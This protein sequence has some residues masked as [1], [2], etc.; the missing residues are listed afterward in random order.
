MAEA[1]SPPGSLH[2][3]LIGINAYPAHVRQLYGCVNDIDAVERLLL[4]TP[5][6]GV[7]AEMI[8]A[9]RLESQ[10]S[11]AT[12]SSRLPAQPATKAN[13]VKA[14]RALTG[15]RVGPDDRVLIYYSG[16]GH[17]LRWRG[18]TAWHEALVP[19][20][21]NFLYD[22]EMDALINSIAERTRDVTVIL[23]CCH[24]AS[25]FRGDLV[26]AEDGGNARLLES[27]DRAAADDFR[28]GPRP[29]ASILSL[30]R[31][32]DGEGELSGMLRARTP[33][34][35][36]VAAAQADERAFETP[37]DGHPQGR[38]TLGLLRLVEGLNTEQRAA[39][40]WG[41]IW[42]DL[43][44]QV[45][46]LAS[47]GKEQHPWL[48]GRPERRV[49]GGD[50]MPQAMDLGYPVTQTQ[51][52]VFGIKAGTLVGVTDGAQV[53]V[54]RRDEPARF[55]VLD[56]P[57]DMAARLGTLV[58]ERAE[59][60]TSLARPLDTSFT[61]QGEGRGR[62]VLPGAAARLKVRLDSP[63]EQ[64]AEAL[65]ASPL[66]ELVPPD[67]VD[68]EVFVAGTMNS[69]WLIS[70]AVT[71]GIAS[72]PSMELKA[73]RAGI[74]H[75]AAYNTTLRL[76][77]T[78]DVE[79]RGRL[80]VTLLDCA[81]WNADEAADAMRPELPEAAREGGIYSLTT[82]TRIAIQVAHTGQ[83]DE[84]PRLYVTAL[85]CS[86]FGVIEKIGEVTLRPAD[87]Q[88]MWLPGEVGR[89][90]EVWPSGPRPG[91]PSDAAATDRL[92]IIGTTRPG[93]ALD[94]LALDRTVQQAVD[95]NITF[96]GSLLDEDRAVNAVPETAAP[97]ELWT[98]QII[99]IRIKPGA[100][101]A[102]PY[103]KRA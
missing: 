69:G 79:L 18:G 38:L 81:R 73:L 102:G 7:P 24:A 97:A 66:L 76:G 36:A 42:V 64:A 84:Q 71:L 89:P 22:V 1:S 57:E 3:V 93:V 74:E 12:S 16:H 17:Q 62:L 82:G 49:F 45:D 75:Y 54:Y 96:R 51:P 13:I 9:T 99:P 56:S 103:Q 10:H 61:L 28:M 58:V 90:F 15:S 14:L 26:A 47:P 78:G 100:Y 70:D 27:Q 29:D 68:A 5:G 95:D 43:L 35:V 32:A 87:Q 11:G 52:N 60:A 59:R 91:T 67:A 88:V 50:W 39:L 63:D 53:A 23:D 37:R 21:L 25:A 40:R 6:I 101:Q 31:T 19:A 48:V 4:D 92:V 72:V 85:L 86:A 55:P 46:R 65:R 30:R 77:R 98:G 20:D 80:Q 44:D 2:A 83:G 33:S 94:Y 8:R 34:Y 41:D